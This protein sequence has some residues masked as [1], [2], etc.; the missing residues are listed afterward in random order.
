MIPSDL[1]KKAAALDTFLHDNKKENLPDLPEEEAQLAQS[2]RQMVSNWTPEVLFARQLEE[3][4]RLQFKPARQPKEANKVTGFLRDLAFAALALLF[5]WGLSWSI[6]HLL[7][8]PPA[9]PGSAVVAT[10]TNVLI[11]TTTP[12]VAQLEP[13]LAPNAIRSPLFND[14]QIVLQAGFPQASESANVYL[15]QVE[16][17]ITVDAARQIAAQLGVNGHVY[18]P[19]GSESGKENLIVSDGISRV[20]VSSNRR[21]YYIADYANQLIRQGEPPDEETARKAALD[22]LQTHNLLNLSYRLE[23]A[24]NRYPGTVRLVW[25]VDGLPLHYPNSDAP[26]VYIEVDPNGKVK[27]VE[28]NRIDLEKVGEFP[29]IS[30]EEAWQRI[31]SANP[32]QGVEEYSSYNSKLEGNPQSWQ[33]AFPLDTGLEIYGNLEVLQPAEPDIPTL[34]TFN[35]IPL[36]GNIQNLE[37]YANSG[38]L[39]KLTGVFHQDETGKP[40][41]E[42]QKISESETQWTSIVGEITQEGDQ[43]YIVNETQKVRLIDPP[44]NLPVG[45]QADATGILQDVQNQILDWYWISCGYSSGGGGGGGGSSAPFRELNLSGDRTGFPTPTPIPILV[46]TPMAGTRLEGESGILSMGIR[47]YSDGKQVLE[48]F[49]WLDPSEKY[50]DGLSLKLSGNLSEMEA[51]NQYPVRLWGSLQDNSQPPYLFTVERFEPT[52]PDLKPQTWTGTE[53]EAAIE[54]KQVLLFTDQEGKQYVLKSSIDFDPDNSIGTLQDQIMI[55]GFIYPD[56]SFGGYPV[57]REVSSRVVNIIKND[58]ETQVQEK[59][60][61]P[62]ALQ[63]IPAD[64]G[65]SLNSGIA[66]IVNIELVYYTQDLYFIQNQGDNPSSYYIQPAWLFSGHYQNGNAFEILVQALTEQ[67]LK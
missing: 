22:F 67:Y 38:K 3:K 57:I 12:V 44:A 61:D 49:W 27:T 42:V 63:V 13:T 14:L 33:R 15:Q 25:M 28:Y 6:Q 16:Q 56:A 45:S 2:I 4:L 35:N 37:S 62:F 51:Y 39:L 55:T 66:T 31:I 58:S 18:R 65:S 23:A 32:I 59:E 43:I 21:F 1:D 7:P 24:V 8:K 20:F 9:Q 10:P 54:G 17:P 41:F 19:L 64:L 60:N 48:A 5:I 40:V 50:P 30:A 36:Q 52:Y 34:F 47:Q 11:P 26:S 53:Q 46:P 29:M